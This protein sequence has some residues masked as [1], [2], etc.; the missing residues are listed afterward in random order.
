M[1]NLMWSVVNDT[2]VVHVFG[3]NSGKKSDT[4]YYAR[5]FIPAETDEIRA[6]WFISE[7]ISI[8]SKEIR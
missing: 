5:K 2:T 1:K 3:L 7:K 6:V 8:A 4:P